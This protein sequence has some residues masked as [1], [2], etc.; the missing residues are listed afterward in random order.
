MDTSPPTTPVL[1]LTDKEDGQTQD[2][3]DQFIRQALESVVFH[4]LAK[5]ICWLSERSL[6]ATLMG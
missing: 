4:L 3:Q 1:Q 5:P 6:S 2:T